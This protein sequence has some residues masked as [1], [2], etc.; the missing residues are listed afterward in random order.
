MRRRIEEID[1][2]NGVP[3]DEARLDMIRNMM[4]LDEPVEEKKDEDI[5]NIRS[6]DATPAGDVVPLGGVEIASLSDPIGFEIRHDPAEGATPVAEVLKGGNEV[7]ATEE[8]D[9]VKQDEELKKDSDGDGIVDFLDSSQYG[10]GNSIDSDGDGNLDFLDW[11]GSESQIEQWYDKDFERKLEARKEEAMGSFLSLM[12]M[13]NN[14]DLTKALGNFTE[15]GGDAMIVMAAAGIAQVAFMYNANI[16]ELFPNYIFSK[17]DVRQLM[18][19]YNNKS[20]EAK[21]KNLLALNRFIEDMSEN[22]VIAKLQE[23]FN[24]V[25]FA[26]TLKKDNSVKTMPDKS[27]MEAALPKEP[28][29]E[30]SALTPPQA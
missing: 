26:S 4:G 9:A 10:D 25:K 1:G 17:E 30:K 7:K 8:T 3:D 15:H 22:P 13:L 21:I 29:S 6:I 2:I 12:P 5:S 28:E 18:N 27:S 11:T 19:Q 14:F 20:K 16:K 23:S 24:S